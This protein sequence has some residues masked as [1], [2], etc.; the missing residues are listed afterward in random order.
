MLLIRCA[1]NVPSDVICRVRPSLE[2]AACRWAG[3]G[4]AF[5]YCLP[6]P[7]GPRELMIRVST[8]R[9]VVPVLF[10]LDRLGATDI[11]NALAGT[12]MRGDL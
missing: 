2:R 3:L 4:E 5:V 9:A 6:E 12:L 1:P 7:G 8:A 10:R 11:E